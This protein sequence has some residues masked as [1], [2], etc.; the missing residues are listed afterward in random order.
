MEIRLHQNESYW[1]LDDALVSRIPAPTRDE[2]ST[3]PNY[4]ALRSLI[5]TYAEL[6][7]AC[8]T[9][10]PGSDAGIVSIAEYCQA[11][12]KDILLP[13][14]TFYGYES[15]FHRRGIHYRPFYFDEE[16]GAWKFPLDA[17]VRSLTDRSAVFLCNPNNPLGSSIPTAS[18]EV[19]QREAK[20][21]GAILVVDEAY[22]EF[23]G[24]T[25]SDSVADESCIILRSL[26]KGFGLSGGRV[27]YVLST[28]RVATSLAHTLLPWPIAHESSLRAIF[29]LS[30]RDH[31]AGR[32]EAVH[33]ARHDLATEL[34]VL[35]IHVYESTANFLLIRTPQ[36]RS[37]KE[38]LEAQ[39][40]RVALGEQLAYDLH[41][42][43]LLK[44]TLRI[45]VPS[46]EHAAR[47]LT[48]VKT[49]MPDLM[50]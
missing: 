23:S 25:V 9:L 48:A 43:E 15:T 41:A 32:R 26:S 42:K 12:G 5:A 21:C 28:E 20:R 8:V 33:A 44:D 17:V 29:L 35:D 31:L 2:L 19:L 13:L 22:Y 16:D 46:P 7:P 11:T 45:A 24:N 34:K 27:G 30:E 10:T 6:E 40:I 37:L 4:D 49:S 47:F 1:L 14:P 50:K 39:S 36:A 3:Y 18:M 38:S